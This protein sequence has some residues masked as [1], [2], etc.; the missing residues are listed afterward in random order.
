MKPPKPKPKPRKKAPKLKPK[1][2]SGPAL[3]KALEEFLDREDPGWR[4]RREYRPKED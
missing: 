4:I 1:L 3:D 2:L